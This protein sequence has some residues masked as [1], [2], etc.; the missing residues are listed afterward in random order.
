M[1]TEQLTAAAAVAPPTTSVSV[2]VATRGSARLSACLAALFS[3]AT[4]AD[5]VIVVDARGSL[6]APAR[7]TDVPGV[8]IIRRDPAPSLADARLAG[9]VAATGDV[10]ALVDD[11]LVVDPDWLDHLRET[12]ADPRV[13]A[14]GG[15]VR[16]GRD[17]EAALGVGD[18]GR[19][20]PNGELTRNFAADP[21]R[22]IEVDHLPTANF[23]VRR[24]AWDAVGGLDV[25]FPDAGRFAETDLALRLARAGGRLLFVPA[26]AGS[27]PDAEKRP[28][29]RS[30]P[31]ALYLRRRCHAAMLAGVAGPFAPIVRHYAATTVRAQRMR[32]VE[33]A[34]L[35]TPYWGRA[36][37]TRRP[38]RRRLDAPLPLGYAVAEISGL[39]AGIVAGRRHRNGRPAHE[40]AVVAS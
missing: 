38:L 9:A 18:I 25:R 30:D 37:G 3:Q 31:R 17:G 28:Y 35:T 39:I 5:E 12:F 7:I 10:L 34:M 4:T 16:E 22:T 15:R 23:A 13:V 1:P 14:A 26:A 20:L 36:D 8:R 29:G 6:A 21:G 33:A 11:E 27:L 24:A 2:I 32:L 40:S 19:L